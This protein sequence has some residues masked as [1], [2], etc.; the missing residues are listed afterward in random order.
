MYQYL[1][2]RNGD[3]AELNSQG[4]KS[5]IDAKL[6]SLG[7]WEHRVNFTENNAR[8]SVYT[9][10]GIKTIPKQNTYFKSILLGGKSFDDY[11]VARGY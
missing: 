5:L 10:I 2:S 9:K 11:L 7:L 3:K 1:I 8:I 6:P 4:L